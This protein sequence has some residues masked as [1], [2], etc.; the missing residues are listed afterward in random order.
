MVRVF[1]IER[2]ALVLTACTL[3]EDVNQKNNIYSLS[4]DV[5]FIHGIII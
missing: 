2:S 3:N 5:L 4:T 1:L